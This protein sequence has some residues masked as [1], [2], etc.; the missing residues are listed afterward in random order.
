MRSTHLRWCWQ[1]SFYSE[2]LLHPC[3]EQ[4]DVI[5]CG[6]SMVIDVM[7]SMVMFAVMVM[8][9]LEEDRG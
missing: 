3:I 6:H 2:I 9:T 4:I 1:V 7:L 5:E 8:A